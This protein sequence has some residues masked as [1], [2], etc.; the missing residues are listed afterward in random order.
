LRAIESVLSTQTKVDDTR[1]RKRQSDVMPR[2]LA[3]IA[4]SKMNPKV[5][6][7]VAN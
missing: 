7:L 3:L 6:E 4:D 2:L 5:L 1:L